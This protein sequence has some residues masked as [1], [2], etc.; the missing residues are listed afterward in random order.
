MSLRDLKTSY[1]GIEFYS[2]TGTNYISG[3]ALRYQYDRQR[4]IIVFYYF[5]SNTSRWVKSIQDLDKATQTSPTPIIQNPLVFKWF[6]FGR[7][8]AV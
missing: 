5:D 4:N 6:N 7:H 2:I 3:D 1:G 8:Q